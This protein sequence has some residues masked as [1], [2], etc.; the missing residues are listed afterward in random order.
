MTI[1]VIGSQ[2]MLGRDCVEVLSQSHEVVPF[3]KTDL[4]ITDSVAVHTVLSQ[5]PDLDA[6]IN[7][8]AYTDVDGAES[9]S[10]AAFL[11]NETGPLNLATWCQNHEVTLVHFSTDY[12]FDGT[13]TAPYTEKDSVAPINRYGASKLAGEVAIRDTTDRH[14]IFRIQWLYGHHGAHFVKTMSTLLRTKPELSVVND[15]MGALTWTRDVAVTLRRAIQTKIPYGTYHLAATGY[16]SWFDIAR[17]IATISD[18]PI[19]I[20]PVPSTAFPRPA[21]RP[22]NSRLNCEKLWATG[23]PKIPYWD[24]RLTEFLQPFE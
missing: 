5:I 7:C 1:A 23:I 12:V 3:S 14:Y 21:Q 20:H 13:G 22:H 15:Q 11:I 2:G 17:H 16:G 6:V 19:P 10:D 8:A 9:Q 24:E 4:D 18:L